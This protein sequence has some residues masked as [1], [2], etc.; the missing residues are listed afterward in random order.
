MVALRLLLGSGVGDAVGAGK[1]PVEMVETAV[2][3]VDH[4]DGL[5]LR[6]IDREGGQRGGSS[7]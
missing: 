5:D 1:Q 4:D 2:L 6:Q 3:G 7:A